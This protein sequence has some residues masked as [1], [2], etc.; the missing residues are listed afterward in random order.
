MSISSYIS[1]F[2]N[3]LNDPESSFSKI[4]NMVV[5][6]IA[7]I[8][9]ILMIML[10]FPLLVVYLSLM[11]VGYIRG[12]INTW[13]CF[14]LA[15]PLIYT[16]EMVYRNDKNYFDKFVTLCK[17]WIIIS[18]MILVDAFY[19]QLFSL[20]P[21]YSYLQFGLVYA[22]IRADFSFCNTVFAAWAKY[23]PIL[24]QICAN[25]QKKIVGLIVM[26]SVKSGLIGDNNVGKGNREN[27]TS[28]PNVTNQSDV[29]VT[30]QSDVNVTNQSDVPDQF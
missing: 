12:I 8:S 25:V 3:Y 7:M 6:K 22:L 17:Y 29:N 14:G 4:S 5:Q 16:Y 2:L 19:G 1:A 11:I 20:L 23:N 13:Q 28:L 10:N 18:L 27:N 15:Y 9:S 21:G 30:N 26:T 24:L